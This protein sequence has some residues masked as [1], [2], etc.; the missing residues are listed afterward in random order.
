MKAQ[1]AS[2]IRQGFTPIKI[3]GGYRVRCS[4]CEALVINDVACHETG[5]PNATHECEGCNEL[6][7]RRQRYC[8]ECAS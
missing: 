8:D 5:C 6:I 4:A 7:P 2:L 3:T 1:A